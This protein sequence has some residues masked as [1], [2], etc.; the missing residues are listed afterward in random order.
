VFGARRES[1][2]A[3][4]DEEPDRGKWEIYECSRPRQSQQEENPSLNSNPLCEGFYVAVGGM[5]S[6][7]MAALKPSVVRSV[8]T[9]G[10]AGTLN[11][12]GGHLIEAMHNVVDHPSLRFRDSATTSSPP[13]VRPMLGL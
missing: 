5:T 11:D 10:A 7:L 3:N 9:W 12:P 4:P 8:V 2:L 1:F 6:L 13:M